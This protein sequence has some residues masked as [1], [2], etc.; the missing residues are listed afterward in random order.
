[1]VPSYHAD[2]T[3]PTHPTTISLDE[4][5]ALEAI[6]RDVTTELYAAAS[7]DVAR[8]FG[9]QHRRVDDGIWSVSQVLDHIMFCRVQGLGVAQPARAETVD[10]AIADFEATNVKNWIIQ[11]APGADELARLLAARGF[12]RHP[13]TWAKFIH[14]GDPPTS[15]TEL[16]IREI[17]A[18][19][20]RAFGEVGAA[21]FGLPAPA[22]PW[23]ASIVGGPNFRTFM[24]FAGETPVAGGTVFTKD[25]GAWLGFGG[26]LASHRGSGAQ[27]AILAARIRAAQ[28]AGARLIS[29]E[30]GIPHEGEAGPSF[31]NIQRAGFRIA[32]ERPNMRRAAST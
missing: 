22:A 7:A 6:E 8:R 28:D 25:G 9:L 26:T 1:M 29:T 18:R 14:A 5:I 32:Y 23:I 24:A 27:T 13:R 11:L 20:A 4:V 31:K 2:M 21:A 10:A 17:D 15:R 12:E 30:T 3:N 19:H 16:I